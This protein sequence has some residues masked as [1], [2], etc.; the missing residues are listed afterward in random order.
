MALRINS[1]LIPSAAASPHSQHA[2]SVIPRYRSGQKGHVQAKAPAIPLTEPGRLSVAN[3]MHLL[4]ISHSALYAGIPRR[5]PSPD[6]YEG[7]KPY[8]DTQT[9]R[10]FKEREDAT[11]AEYE[12]TFGKPW[13]RNKKR[14]RPVPVAQSCM[15]NITNAQ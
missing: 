9:I 8:W 5:F 3:V 14:T 2:T 10:E 7:N 13:P 12:R 15:T 4:D 11:H 1:V 6:F